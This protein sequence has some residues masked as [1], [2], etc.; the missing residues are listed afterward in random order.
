[1]APQS[2]NRRSASTQKGGLAWVPRA[3]V[4]GGGEDLLTGIHRV[5][6]DEAEILSVA[7]GKW[8]RDMGCVQG[9]RQKRG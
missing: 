4:G 5:P 2:P 6:C 3:Q 1:M 8:R 7:S 9:G